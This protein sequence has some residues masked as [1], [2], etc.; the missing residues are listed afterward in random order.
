M[1]QWG[2]KTDYTLVQDKK[3][4]AMGPEVRRFG[5][6]LLQKGFSS[7]VNRLFE[8]G[9]PTSQFGES[10][11][12]T[13]EDQGEVD[14]SGAWVGCPVISRAMWLFGWGMEYTVDILLV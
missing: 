7:V 9:V 4:Q 8:L 13:K 10:V 2:C 12:F 14:S 1:T 6:T 5:G 3:V 11:L